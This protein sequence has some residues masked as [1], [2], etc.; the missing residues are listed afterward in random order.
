MPRRRGYDYCD[1]CD[2]ESEL[3]V[4]WPQCTGCGSHYCDTC[5]TP[6]SVYEDEGRSYCYCWSCHDLDQAEEDDDDYEDDWASGEED[7]TDVEMD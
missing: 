7:V 2:A 5:Y 6:G 4:E 3:Y 1:S